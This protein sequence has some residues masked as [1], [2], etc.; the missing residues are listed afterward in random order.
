MPSLTTQDG[1][2]V[3]RDD[4]LGTEQECCCAEG[5]CCELSFTIVLCL[6][7]PGSEL[8]NI[9]AIKVDPIQDSC[10]A[11]CEDADPALLPER[12]HVCISGVTT[13][14]DCAA[15]A[16]EYEDAGFVDV[17]Y[18][19]SPAPGLVCFDITQPGQYPSWFAGSV[20]VGEKTFSIGE[21]FYGVPAEVVPGFCASCGTDADCDEGEH[22]C[23]GSCVQYPCVCGDSGDCPPELPVC[24]DELC[25]DASLDCPP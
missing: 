11:E 20:V 25:E 21:T 5:G 1:K 15:Q 22:C 3:L 24:C 2:L 14:G 10:P 16:Q 17:Q 13:S 12:Y 7:P 19:F 6:C 9:K 8:D 4:K 18:T 23:L